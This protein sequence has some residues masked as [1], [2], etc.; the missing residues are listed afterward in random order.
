MV[1]IDKLEKGPLE[2]RYSLLLTDAMREELGMWAEVAGWSIAKTVR[3]LLILA[4][5]T[6]EADKARDR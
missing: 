5:R 1:E 2:R 4:M 6:F 3:Y